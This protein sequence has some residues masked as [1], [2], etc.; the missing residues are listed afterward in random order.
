MPKISQFT[1][2][3]GASVA[4]GDL[5]PIVDVGSPNVSEYI[6]ADELAQMPQLSSRYVPLANDRAWLPAEMFR[7]TLNSAN[8]THL[9][10]IDNGF[11][12]PCMNFDSDAI[13]LAAAVDWVP[14]SW[15]TV[16]Y[17]LWW[18]NAGAGAGDC[19][20]YAIALSLADGVSI[21]SGN[22]IG[23]S[24]PGQ[25]LTAPAQNVVKRSKLNTTAEP[26][27]ASSPL[28]VLVGRVGSDAADTLGND[29][30]LLG[31]EIVRV[32]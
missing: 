11:D 19:M 27:T 7:A 21:D 8:Q 24:Y 20:W 3:T 17:Y 28:R 13:E 1:A 18:S 23:P 6:T 2:Q 10:G 29:A 14:Q 15:S 32:S 25:A 16:D 31:I 26:V 9:D 22:V 5:F 30:A 12:T 4:N